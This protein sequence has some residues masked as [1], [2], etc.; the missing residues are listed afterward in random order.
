MNGVRSF[1]PAHTRSP[2]SVMLKIFFKADTF[3]YPK[4]NFGT[5]VLFECPLMYN[6]H[7]DLC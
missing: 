6:H 2:M 3:W 1:S 4:Q 7:G 5:N